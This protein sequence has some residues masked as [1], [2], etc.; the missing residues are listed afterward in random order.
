[1]PGAL[2]L[3]VQPA[4]A[5]PYAVSGESTTY[6][7]M[8]TSLEDKDIYP[9]YEYLRFSVAMP[10]KDG[11]ATSLNLGAWGRL[12]LADRWTDE[13]VDADLQYGYLSYR[14]AKNNLAVNAGRQ[15]VTEGVA[16]ER[17]DGLYLRSDLALGFSAAAFAGSPVITEPSFQG[18][19]FLYGARVAHGNKGL[20]SV[21]LSALKSEGEDD[22]GEREEQGLDLWLHPVKQVD[23]TGRSTYNTLSSGWMEHAYT[24]SYAPLDALTTSVE[25][26][27]VNYDDY[28]HQVTTSALSLTNGIIQPRERV[29][30][31]GV[32]GAYQ[33]TK[34]LAVGADYRRYNYRI[35][36]GAGYFGGFASYAADSLSAGVSLHRMY[37]DTDRLRYTDYRLYAT[38]RIG[39]AD[40]AAEF[41]NVY[42]DKRVYGVKNSFALSGSAGY[43]FTER[44]RIW[45]DLEYGQNADFDHELR[46]LIKLAWAFDTKLNEGGG[47][48]EK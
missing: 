29:T 18:G 3:A 32:K 2:L 19:E 27:R 13:R 26:S 25:F 16:T 20:Y 11:S 5:E 23:V 8:R 1:M 22:R 7:R 36:E 47:K 9:L 10:E 42:Y 24:V 39:K 38:K 28:F 46:G 41:F 48:S 37:G 44:L 34:S 15:L 33:A 30:T 35:A 31:F 12:D 17:I 43:R 4:V 14:G 6:L 40:L 45:G 21:G